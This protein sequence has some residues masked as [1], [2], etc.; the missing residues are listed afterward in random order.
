MPK[1]IHEQPKAVK[2]TLVEEFL[3]LNWYVKISGS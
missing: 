1:E 3:C 2:D